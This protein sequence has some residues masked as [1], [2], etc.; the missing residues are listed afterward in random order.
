MQH[1]FEIISC[2][3][4]LW[5]DPVLIGATTLARSTYSHLMVVAF[6]FESFTIM[7]VNCIVSMLIAQREV[8]NEQDALD[9]REFSERALCDIIWLSR[10]KPG[11][12]LLC[13]LSRARAGTRRS[14]FCPG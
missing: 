4:P 10:Q 9:F 1:P 12:R 2:R 13:R 11:P 6:S 7:A 3:R 8:A 5:Q 14:N